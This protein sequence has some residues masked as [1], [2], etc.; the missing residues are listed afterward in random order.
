VHVF[1]LPEKLARKRVAKTVRVRRG[2]GQPTLFFE[3]HNRSKESLGTGAAG[4]VAIVTLNDRSM[5]VKN[6]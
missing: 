3:R 4:E 2:K 5:S 1:V 6:K